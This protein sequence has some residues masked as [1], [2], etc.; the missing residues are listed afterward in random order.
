[1]KVEIELVENSTDSTVW[2]GWKVTTGEKYADGLGYDEMLG[3][4]AA[5][6]MPQERPTLHWLKTK[7]QHLQRRL[8]LEA[9]SQQQY[10]E[11]NGPKV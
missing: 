7:E 9:Q 4:V 8:A 6:T 1:M 10:L 11:Q 5:I 2:N 3:L